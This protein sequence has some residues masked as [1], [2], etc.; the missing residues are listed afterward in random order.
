MP[1]QNHMESEFLKAYENYAD[2][3][4][5]HCFFR[6]HDHEH[7]KDLVQETYM[8][9]WNYLAEDGTIDNF[10]AFLYRTMNNLII[11]AYRKH[12]TDSLDQ[13][14]EG[15]FDVAGE[16]AEHLR[17]KAEAKEIIALFDQLNEEEKT[18][19]TLR[20]VDG[21]EPKEIAAHLGISANVVSVRIHRALSEVRSLLHVTSNI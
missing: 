18:V 13:L 6:I 9:T 2:A 7:A 20:F 17:N 5:R 14:L 16:D 12:H 10:R 4:F 19:L 11:D 3:L 8:K 21:W 1:Q 15:G